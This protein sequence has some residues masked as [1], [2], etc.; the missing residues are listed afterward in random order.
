[1]KFYLI[2]FGSID[3]IEFQMKTGGSK[4]PPAYH[5]LAANDVQAAANKKITA[6]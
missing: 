5:P 6:W 1:M 3:F 2:A 4:E